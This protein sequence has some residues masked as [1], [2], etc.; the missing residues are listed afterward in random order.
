MLLV[1]AVVLSASASFACGAPSKPA[2]DPTQGSLGANSSVMTSGATNPYATFVAAGAMNISAA[3]VSFQNGSVATSAITN[4][5]A[6]TTNP[7]AAVG[8]FGGGAYAN[9]MQSF[10][11][12]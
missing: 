1:I 3:R 11:V 7:Y 12:R 2:V 5:S 4:G 6:F 9:I 8:A 10:S